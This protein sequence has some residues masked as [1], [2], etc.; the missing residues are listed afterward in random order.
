[1]IKPTKHKF[2]HMK[3]K[4]RERTKLYQCVL[5]DP[6]NDILNNKNK[7][8]FFVMLQLAKIYFNNLSPIGH[9]PYLENIFTLFSDRRE[10]NI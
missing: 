5:I 8:I 7:E 10:N 6:P 2:S 3:F 4:K 9:F 1:M